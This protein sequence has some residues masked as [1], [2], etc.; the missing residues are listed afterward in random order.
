MTSSPQLPERTQTYKHM[1]TDTD[2]WDSYVSRDDD[3]FVCTL[4]KNGTTWM[5]AICALLI[6]Q[7]PELDF[8]PA[9]RSPWLDVTFEPIDEV[10]TALEAQTKR[11]VIKTHTP[12][13]GIPYLE[14]CTYITVY[15]DPRDAFFSMRNHMDNMK[16]FAIDAPDLEP[17]EGFRHFVEAAYTPGAMPMGLEAAVAHYDS[18]WNF[19]HLPNIHFFHYSDLKRD[20]RGEMGKVAQALGI[21][22]EDD[23][24]T[25]LAKSA[26]FENMKSKPEQFIPGAN[27]DAWHDP[28]RFL[29]KGT[30]G[31]WKDVLSPETLDAF[32]TKLA[33][34]LP[35]DRAQWLKQG[36]G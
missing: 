33:A 17:D 6:F 15:R 20:L 31:Q 1:L 35:P 4:G 36:A 7:T 32:K 13:D 27:R 5:Q 14:S 18:Y 22:V 19:R 24:L 11:R 16:L 26:S 9:E 2:R 10:I 25:S 21:E 28:S 34:L 12:L 30:S 29:H 3:V 23:M 8:N